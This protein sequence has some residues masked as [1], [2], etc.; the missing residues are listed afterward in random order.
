MNPSRFPLPARIT[1]RWI[2]ALSD[3]DLQSAY[4][5]ADAE[6]E[7]SFACVDRR[8]RGKARRRFEKILDERAKRHEE[9]KKIGMETSGHGI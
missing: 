7:A 6:Q 3:A 4:L 8:E 5:Q 1:R 2:A 9:K